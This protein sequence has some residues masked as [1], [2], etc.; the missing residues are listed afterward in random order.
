MRI[1]ASMRRFLFIIFIVLL[2]TVAYSVV[3][4]LIHNRIQ[5]AELD[6]T[7]FA[8]VD[9]EAYQQDGED[10]DG[11]DAK[12]F[13]KMQDHSYIFGYYF[14]K[15]ELLDSTTG[16]ASI[17]DT[18]YL[19]IEK[20]N[21]E[22][23]QVTLNRRVIATYG[24][25]G[26]HS[27]IWDSI[28]FIPFRESELY[29]YDNRLT[30]ELFSPSKTGINGNIYMLT[31]KNGYTHYVLNAVLEELSQST[32]YI[33]LIAA[34][35]L[36]I[37]ILALRKQLNYRRGY[38][39]YGLTCV[40]LSL[41]MANFVEIPYTFVS[42]MAFKKIIMVGYHASVFFLFLSVSHFLNAPRK[43]N[44][45]LWSLLVVILS[46]VI[47]F[48]RIEYGKLAE[49]LNYL[50]IVNSIFILIY[51]I[52]YRKRDLQKVTI[53]S[54]GLLMTTIS[55]FNL[56]VF[57][58]VNNYVPE[59]LQISF[60]ILVFIGM[61]GYLVFIEFWEIGEEYARQFERWTVGNAKDKE[62]EDGDSSLVQK[63]IQEGFLCI[64]NRHRV[65]APVNNVCFGIF[66]DD[67]L[68][69]AIEEVL[70]PED[71]EEA[72]FLKEILDAI[73][74]QDRN[75]VE[76]F[77]ELLPQEIKRN[78][79]L[80]VLQYRYD[81]YHR[82]LDVFLNDVTQLRRLEHIIDKKEE[83][84][85]FIINALKH[86]R[87]LS[88]LLMH[89]R[90]MMKQMETYA[91]D[92]RAMRMI[93]TLKGNMGQFGFKSV[94]YELHR[95]E[96]KFEA[97]RGKDKTYRMECAKSCHNA[98]NEALEKDFKM[99]HKA[100]DQ[101]ELERYQDTFIVTNSQIDEIKKFFLAHYKEV[102][103]AVEF[104]RRLDEIRFINLKDILKDYDEYIEELA[105]VMGKSVLPLQVQ[106]QDYY[107]DPYKMD[108]LTWHI[109]AIFRNCIAHGIETAEERVNKGKDSYGQIIVSI[110]PAFGTS[111]RLEIRISDDGQGIN[112]EAVR[113]K[114]LDRELMSREELDV[115]R[116]EEVLQLL[117]EDRM[118]LRK[119]VD[120]I[121]GRGVGLSSV[122]EAVEQM[123]GFVYLLSDYGQSTDII[124]NI[125]M[126][127]IS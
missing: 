102:P 75:S 30:I 83:E 57:E 91:M 93:H 61:G 74:E 126:S 33:A 6:K 97:S 58:G 41:V 53:I 48:D 104:L 101:G 85:R 70:F 31:D 5:H 49:V 103:H 37:I 113:V 18:W 81:F 121:A 54:V 13:T 73:F 69:K 38:I 125:P 40:T 67:L 84:K 63:R 90:R 77:V 98:L 26:G 14:D 88:N 35:F 87:E 24:N 28:Y 112:P 79:R 115:M 52:H 15:L 72:C 114:A 29:S 66:G 9:G 7:T 108:A 4:S 107:V 106:G 111:N 119:E 43:F 47:V 12:Q 36:A 96:S 19:V 62:Q 22:Y 64:G 116:D 2:L 120:L 44:P 123:D 110:R 122:R 68:G 100:L 8:L 76:G 109:S 105:S 25:P 117:F 1:S 118:S 94:E 56:I 127:K 10:L 23:M 50:L 16:N 3:M 17:P 39:Y 51:L 95:V 124:L 99:L 21:A 86:R 78:E 32:F 82:K 11:I 55:L 71:E 27:N 80:F 92:E 59:S 65:I 89:F 45:P 60:I 34:I 20:P 42:Y 46:N